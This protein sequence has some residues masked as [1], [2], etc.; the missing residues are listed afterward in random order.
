M[1]VLILALLFIIPYLYIRFLEHRLILFL[2]NVLIPFI[3]FR[4]RLKTIL[5]IVHRILEMPVFGNPR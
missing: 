3:K 5:D 2:R 1:G 4:M